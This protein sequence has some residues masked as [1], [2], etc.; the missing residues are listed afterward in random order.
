M[1]IGDCVTIHQPRHAELRSSYVAAK[2]M[3]CVYE[4]VL[5]ASAAHLELVVIV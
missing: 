1:F 2:L 5:Y 3:W 4:T